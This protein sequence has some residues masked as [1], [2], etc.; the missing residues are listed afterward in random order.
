MCIGWCAHNRIF[1]PFLSV[2]FSIKAGTMRLPASRT[3]PCIFI[4]PG[5]GIAP[6]RSMVRERMNAAATSDIDNARSADSSDYA[7]SPDNIADVLFYGCRYRAKDYLYA[8]EWEQWTSN[9]QLQFHVVFSRDDPVVSPHANTATD[10]VLSSTTETV[11]STSMVLRQ[12]QQSPSHL[13]Q[14]QTQSQ[15]QSQ[16]QRYVQHAIAAQAP[17]L[18]SL[19]HNHH[20][21]IY[22]SGNAQRM[23]DDVIAALKHHVLVGEGGMTV[24]E[25]DAYFQREL[26]RTRR[27]QQETWS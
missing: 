7:R 22:L 11:S 13:Q 23:P 21:H 14:E 10:I 6:M 16:P 12:Q 27:F 1:F 2:A 8:E 18:W 20:A 3:T 25:A 9:G 15:Q 5:L 24:A 19:I 17:Q 26:L 4:G